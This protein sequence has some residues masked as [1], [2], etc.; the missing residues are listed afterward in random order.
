MVDD[1][2]KNLNEKIE[3]FIETLTD[4]E[5]SLFTS[6]LQEKRKIKKMYLVE[7]LGDNKTKI[8]EEEI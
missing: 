2:T 7:S 5:V 4:E 3:V 1:V 8:I 6:M